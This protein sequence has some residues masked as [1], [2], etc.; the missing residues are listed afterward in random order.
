[1]LHIVYFFFRDGFSWATQD[2]QD[3]ER[4]TA[5]HPERIPGIQTWSFGRE[6]S[7]REGSPDFCLVAGFANLSA[8]QAFQTHPDHDRG[9]RAWARVASWRVADIWPDIPSRPFA[10][11][12]P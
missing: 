1:M 3:A 6:S 4:I 7:G 12:T 10:A 8:L 9:K 5:S 11:S 2:A